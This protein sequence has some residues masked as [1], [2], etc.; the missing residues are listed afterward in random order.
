MKG[1]WIVIVLSGLMV[2][3]G[4]VQF[5]DP[6][7]LL[8]VSIYFGVGLVGIMTFFNKVPVILYRALITAL[9]VYMLF[10][11]PDVFSWIREGFPA[12]TGKMAKAR[13]YTELMREFFGLFISALIL[14]YFYRYNKANTN[15]P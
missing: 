11:L 6:D 12:I 4:L 13:P 2:L 14:N 5:N 7:P 9:V 1:K 15:N 3:F 8:W 10:F